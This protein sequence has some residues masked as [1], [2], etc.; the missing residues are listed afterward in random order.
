MARPTHKQYSIRGILLLASVTILIGLFA[1]P[2]A[3]QPPPAAQPPAGTQQP[4]QPAQAGQPQ[5]GQPPATAQT[6][7][8]VPLAASTLAAHPETY[9]G[10]TVTMTAAVE[11]TF[12]KSAFSV[13]QDKTK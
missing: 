1:V 11:Q 10:E 8:F 13:D 7:P 5:R 3:Q 2:R 6:K 9:Y 12:T 4:A